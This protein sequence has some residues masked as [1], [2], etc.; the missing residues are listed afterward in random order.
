M[1]Q[2]TGPGSGC[3][4]R[5]EH[6][7][8]QARRPE[9]QEGPRPSWMPRRGGQRSAYSA[10]T[11]L[12]ACAIFAGIFIAIYLLGKSVEKCQECA[13]RRRRAKKVEQ[14]KLRDEMAK[15]AS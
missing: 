13:E 14:R 10:Y 15:K 7:W 12:A 4:L 8:R 1:A 3:E 6:G 2:G 5:R 9:W 11:V